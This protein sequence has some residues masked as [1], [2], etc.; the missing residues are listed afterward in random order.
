[1]SPPFCSLYLGALAQVTRPGPHSKCVQTR[2]HTW[3]CRP[4]L[5]SVLH[6]LPFF[7]VSGAIFRYELACG[8]TVSQPRPGP[9]RNG[10]S[11]SLTCCPCCVCWALALLRSL[12]PLREAFHRGSPRSTSLAGLCPPA[13]RSAALPAVVPMGGAGGEPRVHGAQMTAP[14]SRGGRG[15]GCV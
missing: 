12:A 10:G 3:P 11:G 14:P 2:I 5:V 9:S 8:V 1:M 15:G 13:L 6:Y 4:P 7:I